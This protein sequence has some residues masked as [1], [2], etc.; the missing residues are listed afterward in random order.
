MFHKPHDCPLCNGTGWKP[1]GNPENPTSYYARCD[2]TYLMIGN[3][4]IATGDAASLL[5]GAMLALPF[6][7]IMLILW[8]V[9]K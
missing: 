4:V 2:H 6:A 5:F 1:Q 8:L 9:T 7:P 3:R